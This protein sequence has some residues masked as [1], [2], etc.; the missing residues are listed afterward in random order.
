MPVG[1]AARGVASDRVFS[2]RVVASTENVAT[3]PASD[4]AVLLDQGLL[5]VSV[6]GIVG[7]LRLVELEEL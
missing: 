7:Q 3:F 2:L 5:E 4:H 6:E 1:G